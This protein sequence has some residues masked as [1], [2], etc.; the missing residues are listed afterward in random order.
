MDQN[1]FSAIETFRLKAGRGVVWGWEER[2][3]WNSRG[4]NEILCFPL[5]YVALFT[6][7]TL[8][9][10]VCCRSLSYFETESSTSFLVNPWQISISW[11]K[12]VMSA[13][14]LIERRLFLPQFSCRNLKISKLKVPALLGM[15]TKT[16]C[17][18]IMPITDPC[19]I[20]N[21]AGSNQQLL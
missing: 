2:R 11:C 20:L 5:Q 21:D 3:G 10:N 19:C 8:H 12:I 6:R 1:Q 16:S 18:V 13:F 4:W 17:G 15:L 9:F 14:Y 7:L